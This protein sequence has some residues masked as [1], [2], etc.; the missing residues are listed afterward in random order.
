MCCPQ[1]GTQSED[2]RLRAILDR[3]DDM[4]NKMTTMSQPSIDSFPRN[5]KTEEKPQTPFSIQAYAFE[6]AGEERRTFNKYS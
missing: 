6:G 2:L 4:E 5:Y 1:T 3:L